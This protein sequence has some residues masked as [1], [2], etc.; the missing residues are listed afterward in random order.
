LTLAACLQCSTPIRQG[1]RFCHTCGSPASPVSPISPGSGGGGTPPD[2]PPRYEVL[3][4]L[5]RGGMGRVYLC[6]DADLDVEVALKV[7]PAE[8][9]EEEEALDQIRKEARAAARFRDC[10][11]ILSLYGFEQFRDT[12]Y[13]VMEFAAGGSLYER[14]KREKSLTEAECRRIGAEVAEALDCAHRRSVIHRDI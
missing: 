3:R 2:L 1:A 4:F 9:T 8:A 12:R 5:G 13:L 10:P 14:L 6:R 7:L 11:G